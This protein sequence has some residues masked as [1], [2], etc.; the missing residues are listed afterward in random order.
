MSDPH[1]LSERFPDVT[2]ARVDLVREPDIAKMFGLGTAQALLIFREGIILYLETGEHSPART[3]DLLTRISALDLG[4]VRAA[5][6]K[7]RAEVAVHM[8]RMCPASRRGSFEQP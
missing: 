4:K 5:I 8:R 7:E 6:A 2:F 1:P 3:A